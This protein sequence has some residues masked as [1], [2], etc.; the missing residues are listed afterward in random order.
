MQGKQCPNTG[1]HRIPAEPDRKV[2]EYAIA[3]VFEIAGARALPL[4]IS[5]R[6][7]IPAYEYQIS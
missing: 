2:V 4:P 3:E 7:S 5:F 1:A 6:C